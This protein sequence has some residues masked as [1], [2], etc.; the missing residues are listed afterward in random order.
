MVF[1]TIQSL[2]IK[3]AVDHFHILWCEFM[4]EPC[5]LLSLILPINHQIKSK[6]SSFNSAI[7]SRAWFR[8]TPSPYRGSRPGH[9]SES[10][11]WHIKIVS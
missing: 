11:N 6:V 10:Y 2:G 4:P 3:V 1:E 8:L 9:L 5:Y 7:G